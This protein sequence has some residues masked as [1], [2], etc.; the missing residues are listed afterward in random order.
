MGKFED[1]VQYIKVT[2]VYDHQFAHNKVSLASI[3]PRGQRPMLGIPCFLSKIKSMAKQP[4]SHQSFK[5]T[6]AI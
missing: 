6:I 1:I 4:L 2:L 5:N 3:L